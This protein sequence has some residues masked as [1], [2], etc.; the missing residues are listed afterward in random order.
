[1]FCFKVYKLNEIVNK[2]LLA[3]NKFM[4]KLHLKQLGFT[5]SACA[6]FTRNKERIENFMQT[7]NTDFTYK[8]EL[9]KACFQHEVAYGKLKDLTRRTQSENFLRD[10]AFK[11]TSDL[12]CDG[13]QRRLASMVYKIF[14]KK[15]SGSGVDPEPNYQLANKLYRQIIR[16]FKRRKVYSS[17]RDNI[18]SVD[19]A[20]MQSL[21]K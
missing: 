20:D 16:T 11:I 12:E 13:Y 14:D 10:E 2:S 5:C 3:G 6:P 1:M 9:D 21:S 17:F 8:N 15:S 18:W 7:G 19:L 4:L